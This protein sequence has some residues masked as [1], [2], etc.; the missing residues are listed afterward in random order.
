MVK[1]L[2]K[3]C[4]I[5]KIVQGKAALFPETPILPEFKVCNH[6]FENVDVDYTVPLF[7]KEKVSNC[8]RMSKYYVLLFK[9]A[10]T[11]AV[12]LKLT[13]DVGVH[14]IILTVRRFIS[15]NGTPKLF[16]SDNFTSIKWKDIKNYLR[17]V[18]I[19]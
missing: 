11:R 8:I 13:P 7:F 1:K 2:L 10:T 16:I 3:N 18:N 6:S 5:C 12:Y 14:S 15:R 19:N 17:N 4:V 9:C